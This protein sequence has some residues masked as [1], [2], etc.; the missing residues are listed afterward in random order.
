VSDYTQADYLVVF[1][2]GS[3]GNPGQGYGS[4]A[5]FDDRGRRLAHTA[6][7]FEGQATNNEAEYQTLLAALRDL[8]GRLAGRARRAVIK[9]LG[10]SQLV[11]RQV[12]GE[13]QARDERMMALRDEVLAELRHFAEYRLAHQSRDDTLQILGH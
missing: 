12:R 5:L 3:R 1:D 6:L 9:V 4:Y 11:I 7:S 2:G 13:W 8:R 10:D